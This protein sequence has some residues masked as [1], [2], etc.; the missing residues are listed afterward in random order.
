MQKL[1][2]LDMLL[3]SAEELGEL[4]LR[5]VLERR[6]ANARWIRRRR[7]DLVVLIGPFWIH[8]APAG[9]KKMWGKW[10]VRCDL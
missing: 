6:V 4:L 3:C 2:E 7:K 1:N 8:V 10:A 5:V 9:T